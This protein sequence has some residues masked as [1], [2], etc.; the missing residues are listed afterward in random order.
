MIADS[1][2]LQER[3]HGRCC[4]H[5]LGCRS[6]LSASSEGSPET[7]MSK[8]RTVAV[9]VVSMLCAS[10]S[11]AQGSDAEC[12]QPNPGSYSAADLSRGFLQHHDHRPSVGK[13]RT[14]GPMYVAC[15]AEV[16]SQ[17]TAYFSATFAAPAVNTIRKQFRTFVT[18]QYGPVSNLQCAG[19]FNQAVVNEQV[20]KWKDSARTTNNAIIDLFGGDKAVKAPQ[21]QSPQSVR[22]EHPRSGFGDGIPRGI[23][24]VPCNTCSGTAANQSSFQR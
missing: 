15:W 14:P 2:R 17:N 9:A 8:V 23:A 22:Y 24:A 20:E 11:Y 18:T 6:T 3:R 4:W 10:V 7:H 13:P 5:L 12:H 1:R 19:K 21:P 16:P